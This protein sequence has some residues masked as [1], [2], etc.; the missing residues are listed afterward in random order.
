MQALTVWLKA[1]FHD[2][3]ASGLAWDSLFL[4]IVMLLGLWACL[5]QPFVMIVMLLGLFGTAFFND[6]A[7]LA[8]PP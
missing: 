1:L 2:L 7:F 3:F 5:G 8:G 6:S 4:M